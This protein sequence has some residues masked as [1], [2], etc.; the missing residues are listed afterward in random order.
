[1]KSSREAFAEAQRVRREARKVRKAP[2]IKVGPGVDKPDDV[3]ADPSDFTVKASVLKD[4][5]KELAISIPKWGL[6]SPDAGEDALTVYH[7]IGEFEQDIFSGAFNQDQAGDFPLRV[8]LEKDADEY[9][10][11]GQH[12]FIFVVTPFNTG[13][14][15]PSDP[16]TLIYD[17]MPPNLDNPPDAVPPIVEVVDG[18]V[19]SVSAILPDYPD[20]APKDVV[21]YYWLDRVPE[22]IDNIPPVD[23]VEVTAANQ[24]LPIPDTLIKAG[25]DGEWFVVYVLVDKAGN[26]SRVSKPMSVVV[27]LGAMPA[28]LKLPEVPLAADD[29]IDRLDAKQGVQVHV[30]EYDNWKSTDEISVSWGATPLEMRPIGEGQNFPVVFSIDPTV[31]RGE[32]DE[33]VLGTQVVNVS[34]EV[35]R[36][37]KSRGS[38]AID[39]NVNFETFGPVDPGTDPD[40]DWPDPINSRLPLCSVYGA[41]SNQANELLPVDDRLN[42]TLKVDLYEGLEEHDLMEFYWGN[43]HI[44]QADYQVKATDSAGDNIT[45]EILWSYIQRTGNTTVPVHYEITRA[46]VPNKPASKNQSVTVSA[47]VVHPDAPGFEGVS[48][49]GW[50]ACE[51][52]VDPAD[53]SLPAA[54][55]VK[56]GDL[57][58]YGLKENHLVT[59]HWKLLHAQSGDVEVLSWEQ[60]IKL[61][62]EYP[63]SGFIWRVEPY[64]DYILPLYEFDDDDHTGR[65]FSWYEFEDPSLREQGLDALI[66]SEVIEQKIAMHGVWGPCPVAFNRPQNNS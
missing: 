58:Q 23:N 21:Y 64:E 26:I 56:V 29:L 15:Q 14:P 28:N 63:P 25:G 54:V 51:A 19:S 59:M 55:R 31:L 8:V 27:A 66:V 17:R 9:G 10:A 7:R 5:A 52:L 6:P 65:A 47:V 33:D 36:G 13:I 46:G 2:V 30:L 12:N 44:T 62:T 11:D 16:L 39:V 35:L 1:M 4:P 43:T 24:S 34:Y 41:K 22:N 20:R 50:L 3:L 48:D 42:A 61:G 53:P 38:K 60:E 18:N 32:Y 49:T 37:G 40:P 57:S 45:A